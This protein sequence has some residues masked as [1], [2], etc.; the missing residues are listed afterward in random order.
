MHNFLNDYFVM[1]H[2][3]FK[4]IQ[5]PIYFRT[6]LKNGYIILFHTLHQ[7]PTIVSFILVKIYTR[8][9]LISD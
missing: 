8:P 5:H 6:I 2:D 4:I 9:R 3:N 1:N 7:F